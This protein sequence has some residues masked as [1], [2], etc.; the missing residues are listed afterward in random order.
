[1]NIRIPENKKY[2]GEKKNLEFFRLMKN[3]WIYLFVHRK[4]TEHVIKTAGKVT[5]QVCQSDLL[6]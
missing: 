1:M 4:E 3:S 6:D 2:L 5:S